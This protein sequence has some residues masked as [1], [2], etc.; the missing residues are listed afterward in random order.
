MSDNHQFRSVR[1]LVD[2]ILVAWTDWIV[3]GHQMLRICGAIGENVDDY[4]GAVSPSAGIIP[5]ADQCWIGEQ[6]TG[7]R[8]IMQEEPDDRL[9]QV[10]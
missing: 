3:D 8:W 1:K 2:R 9:I 10:P 7:D 5:G 6:S 4:L